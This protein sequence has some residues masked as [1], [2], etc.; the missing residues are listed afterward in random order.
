MEFQYEVA[1]GSYSPEAYER[2][3]LDAI[4]GDP[5]LFIRDDEV[6][7][8]WKIIDSIEAGWAAGAPPITFYPAG[9][10]GP[11][12]ADTLLTREGRAWTPLGS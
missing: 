5:T 11:P 10:W 4:L 3:L 1:F 6:E 7:N 9:T 8:A 2:L 12:E